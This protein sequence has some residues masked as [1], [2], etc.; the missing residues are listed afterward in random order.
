MSNAV[1]PNLI[2]EEDPFPL[3]LAEPESRK[4]IEGLGDFLFQLHR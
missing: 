4:D 2:D 1:K 3:K